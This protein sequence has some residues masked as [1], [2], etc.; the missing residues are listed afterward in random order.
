VND[1]DDDAENASSNSIKEP[2]ISSDSE[3]NDP[4]W[5][6]PPEDSREFVI[7]AWYKMLRA[8]RR[9][10][11][12]KEAAKEVASAAHTTKTANMYYIISSFVNI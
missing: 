3:E 9:R 10:Q 7:R 2:V 4:E 5:S 8:D 1:D 6:E 11:A 12:E